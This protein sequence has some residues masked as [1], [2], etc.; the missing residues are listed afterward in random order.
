MTDTPKMTFN[1][2]SII[3]ADLTV[4][5]ADAVR[6][7]YKQVVGWESEAMSMSDESGEYSDYVMKDQAGNWVGGV[8]HARGVNQDIPSQW[9]VHVNVADIQASADRA[10]ALG[11]KIL[12]KSVGDDGTLYYI[13]IQD[14]AGAMLSLTKAG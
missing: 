4:S 12:K 5:N 3:S 9:L 10:I 8:C 13:I 6:D 11:G 2:G 14:P 1:V 7:F